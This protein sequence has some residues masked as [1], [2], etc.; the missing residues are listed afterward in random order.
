MEPMKCRGCK[1]WR[2]MYVN[3]NGCHY[4]IDTG[5]PRGIS[6]EECY[7]G[8]VYFAPRGKAGRAGKPMG[9]IGSTLSSGGPKRND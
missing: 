5:I 1:Y 7:T 8:K 9:R 2:R 6:A 3:H 4:S